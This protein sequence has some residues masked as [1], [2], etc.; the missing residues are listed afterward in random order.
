MEA[1][2]PSKQRPSSTGAGLYVPA[3][4]YVVLTELPRIACW[5]RPRV[6]KGAVMVPGLLSLPF[7]ATT[8][9]AATVGATTPQAGASGS[10]ASIGASS[11]NIEPRKMLRTAVAR[12]TMGVL[13]RIGVNRAHRILQ[14]E[15]T[16]C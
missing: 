13:L 15:L 2:V 14:S 9:N 1:L 11:V 7:V 12:H 4:I 8:K 16:N 5:A 3:R 10:A 6:R